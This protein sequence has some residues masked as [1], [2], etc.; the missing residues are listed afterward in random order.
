MRSMT[1]ETDL[2]IIGA[3]F[4]G[5]YLAKILLSLGYNKFFIVAP[6]KCTVSDK[7]YYNF[8]SRGVR[9]DSLKHSMIST[10]GRMNNFQLVNVMVNHIDD[11]LTYL[12]S[13]TSLKPS[14]IGAQIVS[15]QSFLRELHSASK[16]HRISDEVDTIE[17]KRGYFIV[18]SQHYTILSKRIVFCSGGNRANLSERF[19]DEKV[20]Y[21]AFQ[22]AYS[23]GCEIKM[24]QKM[25]YHPFYSKGVCIPSDDLAHFTIVDENGMGLSRTNE[26]LRAHNAHHRFD[27]ILQEFDKS[28]QCFAVKGNTRIPLEPQPHYRLGGIQ[29]NKHGQT[30][31]PNVYALG[32]CSFGMHGSGRIGGCALSEIIVM[33]RI[34]GT[35]L[36]A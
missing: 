26:L 4:S 25:M 7:S 8:R 19:D 31:R 35:K 13:L 22:L 29:I 12:D 20:E 15:P 32:E 11:E 18:N 14:F 2:L 9:Q 6:N 10:G 21:D 5:L 24:L 34:I 28:R 16:R 36:A 17:R 27:E 23:I 33:S 1:K 3:G 30:S